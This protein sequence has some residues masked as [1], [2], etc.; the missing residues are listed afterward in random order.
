[1]G[2]RFRRRLR[3][4]P[5]LWLNLNK[6]GG[7]LSVGGHGFTENIGPRG[8]QETISARGTGLSYRTKRRSI[9]TSHRPIARRAM[10]QA[11][12]RGFWHWLLFG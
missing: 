11:R 5:G 9:G 4:I 8:H 10:P 6:S 3:I 1:M 2:L 12:R 7:S